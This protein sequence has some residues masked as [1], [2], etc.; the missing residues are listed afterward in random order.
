MKTKKFAWVV[1]LLTGLTVAQNASAASPYDSAYGIQWNFQTGSNGA[2]NPLS[3]ATSSDGTAWIADGHNGNN[4][5]P[6]PWGDDNNGGSW[7]SG[8]GQISR[9]GQILQGQGLPNITDYVNENQSYIRGS[10]SM[11][12]TTAFLAWSA[13]NT[14]FWDNQVPAQVAHY[15]APMTISIAPDGTQG[16]KKNVPRGSSLAFSRNHEMVVSQTSNDMWFVGGYQFNGAEQDMWTAGDGSLPLGS[17]SYSPYIGKFSEAGVM[18]GPA[19]QGNT[20]GRSYYDDVSVNETSGR[21]YASGYTWDA[22][23]GNP[24]YWDVDGDGTADHTFGNTQTEFARGIAAVYDSSFNVL[25]SVIWETGYGDDWILDNVPTSDGGFILAGRT[26]GSHTG[27][28]NPAEGTYDV[29]AAK[30]D[31][32]GAKVWDYQSEA[33]GDDEANSVTVDPDGNVYLGI[34]SNTAGNDDVQIMKLTSAGA[35]V[36]TSTFDNAGS[37]DTQVD[38]ANVSKNKIYVLSENNPSIGGVWTGSTT[39]VPQGTDEILLQKLTPGDFYDSGAM[40]AGQDGF[41]NWDDFQAVEATIAGG[42]L[43]GDTTY[44]FN[45]DGNSTSA[46]VAFFM[47]KIFDSQYGDFNWDGRV[48]EADQAMVDLFAEAT[49]RPEGWN[50]LFDGHVGQNER[51]ALAANFGYGTG[52]SLPSDLTGNGFVDFQDLTI[53]LANWNKIVGADEGNLVDA[54]GSVVNFADLTTLLAAWTGSGPAGSPEAAVAGEAVPEPST[55]VL[56]LV[57]LLGLAL[58]SRRRRRA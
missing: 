47:E 5:D 6:S 18:S 11:Q 43:I 12:G 36:W 34:E 14:A 28:T 16:Y 40:A 56:A 42:D 9:S 24:T 53:L 31:S 54:D 4:P 38:H 23:G 32:T 46:D 55:M 35:V 41:V 1:A 37:Q 33:L 3:V 44:D 7:D 57:G 8:Y 10:L 39:Y 49:V 58:S 27:Y 50:G 52:A 45:E 19:K 22:S 29:Y 26:K 30:Y 51:D 17:P 21:I 2:D 20:D 13:R 25:H 48:D 15:S